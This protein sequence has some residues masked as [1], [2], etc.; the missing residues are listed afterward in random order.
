VGGG[1][2]PN[3][4]ILGYKVNGLL[5]LLHLLS[6]TP[7]LIH[8]PHDSMNRTRRRVQ[9]LGCSRT[10]DNSTGFRSVADGG[11]NIII[12]SCDFYIIIIIIFWQQATG[13]WG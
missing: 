6:S 7:P 4:T 2:A 10:A 3:A 9:G 12:I 5:L 8:S 1:K 11:R 13:R